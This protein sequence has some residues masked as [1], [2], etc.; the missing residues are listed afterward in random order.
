M[1][2]NEITLDEAVQSFQAATSKL[3]V[4]D[5]EDVDTDDEDP[6][7]VYV[8]ESTMEYAESIGAIPATEEDFAAHGD[9]AAIESE[10]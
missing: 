9:W 5:W 7:A 2:N 8:M 1:N 10:E 6:N 4:Q 3:E